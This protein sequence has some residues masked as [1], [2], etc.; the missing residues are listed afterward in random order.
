MNG[1]MWG[2][3]AGG[4]LLIALGLL[5]FLKQLGFISLSFREMVSTFWPLFLIYAGLMN[6]LVNKGRQDGA[7]GLI[8]ILIGGIFQARNLGWTPYS[9]GEMFQFLIPV[10]LILFGIKMIFGRR[11]SRRHDSEYGGSRDSHGHGHGHGNGHWG[12]DWERKLEDKWEEKARKWQ[13][14]ISRREARRGRKADWKNGGVYPEAGEPGVSAGYAPPP[15]PP[16]PPGGSSYERGPDYHY[17]NSYAPPQN[18]SGFIGDVYMGQDYWELTPLNIS[19][20]IGDTSL[21]LT[22]ASIPMGE[23]R[24]NISAFI[25]DVKVF[26]PSDLDVEISVTTSSFIGDMNVL[27]RRED[28]IM[29]SMNYRTPYYQEGAKKIN[30]HV[31][32]FI[33]DIVV[34]KMG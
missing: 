30:L 10:V 23:T 24:I 11:S 33:G 14:K 29:R 12:S 3:L 21:D 34:K 8:L 2:R 7:W 22:K 31:S 25:G 20:F 6:V 19:H 1:S 32:M 16:P 15:P 4:F 9:L 26:I 28:G 27:E 17:V 5:F 13:E 18:K